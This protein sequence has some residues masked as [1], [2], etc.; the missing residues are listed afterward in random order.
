MLRVRKPNG[1]TSGSISTGR[2][3]I[4]SQPSSAPNASTTTFA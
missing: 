2:P 3:T 1:R 4:A